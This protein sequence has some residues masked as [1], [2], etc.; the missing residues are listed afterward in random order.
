MGAGCSPH[1]ELLLK[2]QQNG[3]LACSKLHHGAECLR[4]AGTRRRLAF[5][6]FE[7]LRVFNG[8]R[9]RM[10]RSEMTQQERAAALRRI[11]GRPPRCR[12]VTHQG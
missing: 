6:P 5:N 12:G 10:H 9:L 4:C 2:V 1:V 11:G 8:L 3:K 7:R